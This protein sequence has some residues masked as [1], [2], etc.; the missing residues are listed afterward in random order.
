MSA[1][2]QVKIHWG[3]SAQN[4]MAPVMLKNTS[5]VYGDSKPVKFK[6]HQKNIISV[7]IVL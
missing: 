1:S 3:Y 6:T 5:D 4:P 7:V 2:L